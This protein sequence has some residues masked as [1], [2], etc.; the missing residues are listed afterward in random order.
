MKNLSIVK[1]LES[2]AICLLMF[3][4]ITGCCK[5]GKGV[6]ITDNLNRVPTP[7]PVIDIETTT[8]TTDAM[9][10]VTFATTGVSTALIESTECVTE[11]TVEE[12]TEETTTTEIIDI[13]APMLFI[14]EDEMNVKDEVND[15]VSE[16]SFETYDYGYYPSVA[17]GYITEEERVFLCNTVGTEYG[18]DWVSVYDK[19]LVVDTIMTRVDEG[20]WTNGLESTIY[21]VI[22]APGQYNPWYADTVYHDCVTQSCIDA[23]EYYFQHRDEFPHYDSFYGDGVEN[24]FYKVR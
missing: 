21:N 10:K 6:K 8:S 16:A 18:S 7:Y 14:A 24:H 3:S 19:A 12:T 5:V 11:T 13:A 4:F 20:C 23:V 22:T 17:N 1:G 9:M 15:D 2:I